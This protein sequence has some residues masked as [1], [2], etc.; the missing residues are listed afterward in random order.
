MSLG[1]FIYRS[2]AMKLVPLGFST[3]PSSSEVFKDLKER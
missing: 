2:K 1:N 3:P